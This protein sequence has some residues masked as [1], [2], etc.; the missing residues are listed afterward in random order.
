M[1]SYK[2]SW[3]ESFRDSLPLPAAGV[4]HNSRSKPPSLL[5]GIKNLKS[6]GRATENAFGSST[7][8]GAKPLQDPT[9]AETQPRA[10]GGG[11][12]RPGAGGRLGGAA[13]RRR[14]LTERQASAPRPSLRPG[15]SQRGAGPRQRRLP[16]PHQHQRPPPRRR[17]RQAPGADETRPAPRPGPLIT[18]PALPGRAGAQGGE[19]E[20]RGPARG[21]AAGSGAA[22]PT[23]KDTF[24]ML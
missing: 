6:L 5:L 21:S 15:G 20:R 7:S 24:L 3:L 11:R 12:G 14:R 10:T 9:C 2:G 19:R 16:Q 1:G 17:R 4:G 13:A 18:G 22:L 23:Q 8:P